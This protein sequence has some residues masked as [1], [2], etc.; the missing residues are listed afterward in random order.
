MKKLTALFLALAM[1]FALSACGTENATV[2]ASPEASAEPSA[3][4]SA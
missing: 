3:E 1:I 2:T 4:A